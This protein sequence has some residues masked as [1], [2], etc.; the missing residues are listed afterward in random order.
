[1]THLFNPACLV[2]L[3]NLPGFDDM[4]EVMTGVVAPGVLP[5]ELSLV[6]LG[7]VGVDMFVSTEVVS[8]ACNKGD[9]SQSL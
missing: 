7:F 1:M 2:P 5:L 9:S 4:L 8:A 6:A 3:F